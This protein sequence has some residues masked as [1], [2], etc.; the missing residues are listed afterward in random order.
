MHIS[1]QLITTLFFAS[2]G[3]LVPVCIWLYF[4]L[5]EDRLCPEPKFLIFLTFL[6]GAIG[7][8][9]ALFLE[10]LVYSVNILSFF[11]SQHLSQINDFIRNSMQSGVTLEKLLMVAFFA[12]IIEELVKFFFA[13]FI[14]MRNKANDEPI[15]PI[16]YMIT[17]AL[18]F[19]AIENLFFLIDPLTKNNLIFG[20]L[21]GNMRFIGATLLHTVSSAVIGMFLGFTYFKTRGKKWFY[22]VAG[23]I[24]AILLH[25]AFNFSIIMKG[26][27]NAMLSME[28]IWIVVVIILLLFEKIKNIKL[29]KI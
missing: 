11:S 24:F 25:S 1:T 19:A 23:I 2:I 18:G 16:I 21:T 27:N 22:T 12:P 15:D 5:R 7:T 3:G 13:Y 9:V 26:E 14:A 4:W 6:G 17:A 8:V 29:N 10:K 28:S 20:L